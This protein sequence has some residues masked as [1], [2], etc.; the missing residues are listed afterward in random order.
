MFLVKR[1]PAPAVAL[2]MALVLGLCGLARAQNVT[3]VS[4]ADLTKL[5]ELQV[6]DDAVIAR[7]ARSGV[8]FPVDVAALQRLRNAG[9]SEPLLAAVQ[10]AGQPVNA[11]TYEGILKLVQQG[12]NEN[13]I[14]KRLQG[15]PTTFTLDKTQTAELVKAGASPR[16]LEAL[17][18]IRNHVSSGSDIGDFVVVLDCSG[19]MKERTPEGISK[20]DAAKQVVTRFL[21]EIPEGK[22]LALIVYGTRPTNIK[23]ISC[24]D[25]QVVQHLAPLDAAAKERLALLIS[26]LKPAGATPLALVMQTAGHELSGSQGFSQMVVVTDGMETCNGNPGQVADE[27]TRTLSLPHG[28][29]VVGFGVA[30]QEKQAL[31]DIVAKGKGHFYDA[32]TAPE[33]SSALTRA[34]REAQQQASAAH[35]PGSGLE[36]LPFA[37]QIGWDLGPLKNYF[38]IVR[39]SHDAEKNRVVLLAE[40]RRD[41]DDVRWNYH[42]DA[43]FYD[44]E[45]ARAFS[46]SVGYDPNAGVLKGERL[47]ISFDLPDAETLAKTRRVLFLSAGDKFPPRGIATVEPDRLNN[48]AGHAAWDFSAL[49]KYFALL[50]VRHDAEKNR[51]VLLAESRRDFDDVRWNYHPDARFYDAED[52]RVFSSSVGYDPNAGVLKG[53]RLRISF[54]LPDAETLA[55]T[56]RVA[57]DK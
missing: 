9:A 13:E 27:L 10:K 53:E 37:S 36:G 6:G 45:D 32:R 18:Q 22:R 15:S 19:S 46:S 57:F 51:V 8:A 31:Q 7:V 23:A 24:Q 50:G 1:L 41:F 29:D 12:T 21:R 42:P 17:K 35:F 33:L 44:A 3:P 52:A 11:T 39:A 14:L 54:D 40:S 49:R 20:M 26:R 25:V 43:R 28:I 16:L 5:I 48:L 47:R 30:P 55:K 2:V 4:E 38:D 56:R 34:V